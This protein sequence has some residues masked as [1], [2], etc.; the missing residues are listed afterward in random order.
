MED[1]DTFV[2]F[3]TQEFLVL[4]FSMTQIPQKSCNAI[5]EEFIILHP[6]A[7]N[8]SL[9]TNPKEMHIDAIPDNFKN[10]YSKLIDV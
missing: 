6:R 10:S 4:Y 9:L 1:L 8:N 5:V 2:M 7:S 3:T